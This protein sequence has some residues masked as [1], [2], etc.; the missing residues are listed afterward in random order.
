MKVSLT[1]V[2]STGISLAFALS[3]IRTLFKYPLSFK[4]DGNSTRRKEKCHQ[5]ILQILIS[6]FILHLSVVFIKFGYFPLKL[7]GTL[8]YGRMKFSVYFK[9]EYSL[10]F[11]KIH[12]LSVR[13]RQLFEVHTVFMFV[14]Q[15]T[16]SNTERLLVARRS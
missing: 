13:I 4:Y 10:V 1:S 15:G 6:I 12:I 9:A 11:Q 16:R 2:K 8:A 7:V 14:R 5:N 3:P